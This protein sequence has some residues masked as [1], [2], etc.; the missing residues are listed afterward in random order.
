MK[1]GGPREPIVLPRAAIKS[2]CRIQ[3]DSGAESVSEVSG[4]PGRWLWGLRPGGSNQ[5]NRGAHMA[6]QIS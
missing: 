3:V 2:I 5:W 4:S 1:L 6:L